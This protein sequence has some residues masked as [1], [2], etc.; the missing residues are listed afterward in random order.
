M[1]TGRNTRKEVE[2]EVL[3]LRIAGELFHEIHRRTGIPVSTARAICQRGGLPIR[4]RQERKT[5]PRRRPRPARLATPVP[6]DTTAEPIWCDNCKCK[7]HP[8][9]LAC[10]VRALVA[11]HGGPKP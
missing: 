10:Q 3:R 8:P 2:A 9:C 1:S 5:Q 6:F 4:E 7:V 11:R